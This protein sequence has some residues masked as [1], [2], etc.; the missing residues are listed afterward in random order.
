VTGPR[1][2]LRY[3]LDP[4]VIDT[5]KHDRFHR[6]RLLSMVAHGRIDLTLLLTHAFTLE[7]LPEAYELF[8]RQADGVLK[9]GIYPAA[10]PTHEHP[11]GTPSMPSAER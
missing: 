4:D 9:V 1:H 11:S 3:V 7:Q 5:V 8:S 2:R 6:R 10:C